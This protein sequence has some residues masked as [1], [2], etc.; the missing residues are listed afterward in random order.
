[1]SKPGRNDLCPCGSGRKYKKC[2][3]VKADASQNHLMMLVIGGA[4]V[5]AIVVGILSFTGERATGPTQVWSSEHGHY[6]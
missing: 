3:G 4:V 2:H 6:H 1:M 5:A